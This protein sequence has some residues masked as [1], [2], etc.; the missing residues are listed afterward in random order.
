MPARF[1]QAARREGKSYTDPEAVMRTTAPMLLHVTA[2]FGLARFAEDSRGQDRDKAPKPSEGQPAFRWQVP[3]QPLGATLAD[4]AKAQGLDPNDY[5]IIESPKNLK[6]WGEKEAV[7]SVSAEGR[8]YAV[9]VQPIVPPGVPATA[10]SQLVLLTAEGK[11]LDRIRCEINSREGRV[12]SNVLSQPD[13]DGANMVIRFRGTPIDPWDPNS[14]SGR[15]SCPIWHKIWFH[16]KR[17]VFYVDERKEP[18]NPSGPWAV[19]GLCRITIADNKFSVLFPKLEMPDLSKTK[20]L[21]LTY[22]VYPRGTERRRTIDDPTKVAELLSA[23]KFA[24]RVQRYPEP[25]ERERIGGPGYSLSGIS[26][27]RV[28]FL[29]ADGSVRKTAFGMPNGLMFAPEGS[30]VPVDAR[31]GQLNLANNVFFDAVSKIITNAEGHPVDLL[32]L[33]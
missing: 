3:N 2:V 32:K 25:E 29:M 13:S 17:W 6:A 30:S 11:I 15:Y 14:N 18:K 31:G 5:R 21:R 26:D 8:T 1:G 19:K 4:L 9:A 23:I 12:S 28:D 20:A 24:G 7:V 10:A 27:M 16:G 33:H 22:H